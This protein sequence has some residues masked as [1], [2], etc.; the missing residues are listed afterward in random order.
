MLNAKNQAFIHNLVLKG[1]LSLKRL[2]VL[3]ADFCVTLNVI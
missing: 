2:K 1:N 3:F